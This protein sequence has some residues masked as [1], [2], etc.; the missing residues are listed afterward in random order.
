MGWDGMGLMGG[1]YWLINWLVDRLI[2]RLTGGG[3]W[4]TRPALY[5][6][7]CDP[8]QAPARL[9]HGRT[10]PAHPRDRRLRRRSS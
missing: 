2:D 4:M 8:S 1:G 10:Y 9:P 7:V 3:Q 5:V 6:C